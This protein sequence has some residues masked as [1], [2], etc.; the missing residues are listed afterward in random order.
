MRFLIFTLLLSLACFSACTTSPPEEAI[1]KAARAP[2]NW[3]AL[4]RLYPYDQIDEVALRKAKDWKQEALQRAAASRGTNQTWELAGPTNIGGRV[5][6]LEMPPNDL[7]T[8]Y[9]GSAAGGVFKSDNQGQDWYPIFDD[10]ASLS[11]GDMALAPSNPNTI[12]VGTGESNGGGG[13]LTYDGFGVYR[14]LNAGDTWEH[15][16]LENV[17]TIGRVVVHPTQPNTVF[18]GAMGN[19]FRKNDERGLY[20]TQDGGDTWEQVL[21]LND[22]TGVIDVIIHPQNPDIILAATWERS[23]TVNRISYGG[24]GSG[25]YRSA[26]GG[27]TWT[28]IT[29][30]LPTLAAAKGRI[31]LA[32]A[33]SAPD[34]MYASYATASGSQ[35]GFYRSTNGGINWETRSINGITSV[36]FMWWF[37]RITVA[38]D[39]PEVIYFSG[40]ENHKSNNGGMGWTT[41]FPDVHVDQHATFIHPLDP[42]FVLAGNDGGVFLSNNGGSSYQALTGLPITQFYTCAF[43]FLQPEHLLGGTQDNSS[44]R[45]LSGE[46]DDWE[47]IFFGDGF[48]TLVDPGN[49]DI[50]YASSQFGGLARSD[51]GGAPGTF[52]TVLNGI[53]NSDRRNWKTPVVID[54]N[55]PSTVYYGTYR[56]FKSTNRGESWVPISPDLTNG[57]QTV[58]RRYGTIT[59]I[60]V[61]PYDDDLIY[62]GTDD[63]RVWSTEDGGTN[64]NDLNLGLPNRWVTSVAASP[65]S[66]DEV[67]L[68]Y[69]GYRF[70]ENIGHVYRSSD[71]GQTWVNIQGN[72]PD[73][74]INQIEINPTNGQ[75]YLATDIGVF[76]SENNGSSW[77]LL[78]SELP[79]TVVTSLSYHAPT[80]TLLAGTYGRSMHKYVF[81]PPTSTQ[82]RASLISD[83]RVFPNPV[84]NASTFQFKLHSATSIDVRLYDQN[85]RL[86]TTFFSGR[87]SA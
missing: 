26:D 21:Y 11:I 4:Q 74:P 7:N 32:I 13:S 66:P 43:D 47:I 19:L 71:R 50:V 1:S 42:N 53:P 65:F 59:S 64:W 38:P 86:I 79:N 84:V 24:Q 5:T 70:G 34:T 29:S 80:R 49:S 78:G 45:T 16:G 68:T 61:S 40:F 77:S 39:D 33:P 18:V 81:A 28:E 23:R 35:E 27:A 69:S 41:I 51:F 72:L 56:V 9:V 3:Q 76:I 37:G 85:G 48:Y 8:I 25:I 73:V 55:T 44:M 58:T 67:Y 12:Y 6:D 82:L 87:R 52:Q 22:S 36:G 75:L 46:P 83:A 2:E 10:A 57:N 14:S 20:R 31:A 30:G 62:V 63:G 54:Q 17:G 15:L 60:S